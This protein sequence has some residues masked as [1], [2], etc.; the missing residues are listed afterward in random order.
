MLVTQNGRPVFQFLVAALALLASGA[1]AADV[2]IPSSAFSAG[3]NSAEFHSDVRVFNP[4]SSPVGF[5][6]IFYGSDAAGNV[7]NTVQM[8]FVSIAPR[9]QLS[10]NNVLQSLFN[11]PIGVF[12]PIRF[13][14][15]GTL[16]VSSS[17][18]NVNACGNGS[19]SGQW[20][21]GIDSS[22][23]LKAGTL[24]QLAASAN[25]SSGYHTNVDF[26]NPGTIAANVAVKIRRGDGTL[27]SSAPAPIAVGANGL[28]QKALDDGG[29]FPGV[30]GTT[31][32]NLWAEFT[33][34]QPVL[35]FASVINNGSGDPFAIV[36]TA[37]PSSGAGASVASYTV[38]SNPVAG[39]QVTF[40]DTSSGSPV[41]RFW[42]FG[43]GTFNAAGS[44]VV[45]HSY[46]APGTYK[47]A[48]FVD[49]ASGASSALKDVVV[50]GSSAVAVGISATTTG[51]THWTYT[52]NNVTLHV[53]QPYVITWTTPASEAT[54]HGMGGLA[55]IGIAS[56]DLITATLPCVRSFTPTSGQVGVW[57]YACTNNACGTVPEHNG[58]TGTLTIAP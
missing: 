52:P 49:N 36:M 45:L 38:S 50:A 17:V 18:N 2:L 14:T 35:V 7:V 51:G 37:E 40:T 8:P 34:D 27:L 28:V 55:V 22:Q 29:V 43:D 21:P 56:C 16:I 48:L 58:M 10:Y 12:G 6:P 11:L 1:A 4:T 13:Q 42:A 33:S 24:V 46:G 44:N 39:Q 47:S 31:D 30:S 32:T 41:N 54:A 5:T 23:A 3:K 15:T 57:S 25:G 53:G 26:M 20:L 19:T 9:Q